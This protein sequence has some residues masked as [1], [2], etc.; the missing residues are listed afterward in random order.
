MK[1][2]PKYKEL[3]NLFNKKF[4]LKLADILRFSFY[5]KNQIIIHKD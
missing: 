4:K 2:I 5:A 1:L 3:R